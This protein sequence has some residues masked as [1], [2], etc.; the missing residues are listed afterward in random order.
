MRLIPVLFT[1]GLLS[2]LG[3]HLNAVADSK[4]ASDSSAP[5]I[6]VLGD[7]LSAAYGLP[8]TQGWVHL[9]EVELQKKKPSISVVNASISGDT[10]E[11]ALRRLP[12]A[13]ERFDPDLLI[14]ELGG[15][16]GLRGYPIKKM[17]ENLVALSD[18]AQAQ[19]AETLILG[20]QI[21]SNYG[22]A[23]TE[24]FAAAFSEAANETGAEL[25]PFFL[26]PIALERSYFQRDGI[27]PNSEAQPL[28][29]EHVMTKLVPMLPL[30]PATSSE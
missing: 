14:I 20:M 26:E 5:T 28:L 1:F 9:M 7:S 25:L 8:E 6:L 22:P 24:Q 11:G 30:E 2:L 17:R 21:P 18:M 23:Y 13:L 10:T 29:M 16:D 27:H 19:G 3:V 15:N 4:L 12:A